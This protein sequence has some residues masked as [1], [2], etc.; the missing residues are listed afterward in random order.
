MS[1]SDAT[2]RQRTLA[3]R[4]AA[5]TLAGKST[6]ARCPARQGL[7]RIATSCPVERAARRVVEDRARESAATPGRG[8]GHACGVCRITERARVAA[9][10]GGIVH[11]QAGARRGREG[12]C[13]EHRRHVER[14]Q[15]PFGIVAR[16][17]RPLARRR[18]R[19]RW[20]R[21]MARARRPRAAAPRRDRP[22]RRT[23]SRLAAAS[24]SDSS[25]TAAH[26]AGNPSAN[27]SEN[28]SAPRQS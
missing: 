25:A 13:A 8:I 1:A 19:R 22:S 5:P 10:H 27:S 28:P 18:A 20:L 7:A 26:L 16:S 11:G 12:V 6:A 23:A 17:C 14:H 3:A 15:R 24:P 9:A 4:A 2:R 21:A